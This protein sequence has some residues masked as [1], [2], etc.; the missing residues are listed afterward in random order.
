MPTNELTFSPTLAVRHTATPRAVA[1]RACA[2]HCR[3]RRRLF[4]CARARVSALCVCASMQP[5]A[6]VCMLAALR[7]RQAGEPAA[8][9]SLSNIIPSRS[10]PLTAATV[11]A[12]LSGSLSLTHSLA[13]SLSLSRAID[14]TTTTH[15][16][17]VRL[18]RPVAGGGGG[19]GGR[20]DNRIEK[21]WRGCCVFV[22]ARARRVRVCA[23]LV[24]VAK[25]AVPISGIYRVLR[26]G[27]R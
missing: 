18:A 6:L 4:A 25:R 21:G 22:R 24:V 11:R 15:S 20:V 7:R 14:I 23:R 17:P 2:H 16:L 1:H 8:A 19:N 3:R 12:V 10:R 9:V 26:G 5:R 13:P 27:R